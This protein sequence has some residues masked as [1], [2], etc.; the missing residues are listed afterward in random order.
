MPKPLITDSDLFAVSKQMATMW[1]GRGK[2][3][4][5]LEARMAA[6]VGVKR[7]V[8]FGSGTAALTV[9]LLN[10]RRPVVRIPHVEGCDSLRIAVRAAGMM[11]TTMSDANVTIYPE[12]GDCIED[13]A[14]HLPKE[15]ET[16]LIGRFGVFSF[17]ALKDVTGGIGG[18]LVSH[19]PWLLGADW[20]KLSP[21]SDINAA[22]ILSQ[23]DRYEGHTRLRQ[24]AGG[25]TRESPA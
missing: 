5:E 23:L 15:G 3:V 8:A 14:R 1:I 18:C 19:A 6:W 20:Q 9:A 25:K 16:R 11:E 22:L 17:G 12:R 24:V 7:A 2:R 10:L 4:A 13:F 21:L